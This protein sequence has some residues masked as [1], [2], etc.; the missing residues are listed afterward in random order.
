MRRGI[1]PL[2]KFLQCSMYSMVSVFALKNPIV[3]Y[4]LSSCFALY[5]K[6]LHQTPNE[7][8]IQAHTEIQTKVILLQM[9]CYYERYL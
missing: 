6:V 8:V 1:T 9:H 3:D 2:L 4:I 7:E 5:L